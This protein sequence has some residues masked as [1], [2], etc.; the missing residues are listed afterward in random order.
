MRTPFT[1]NRI[2]TPILIICK[3]TASQSEQASWLVEKDPLIWIN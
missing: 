2:S 1:I 3:T